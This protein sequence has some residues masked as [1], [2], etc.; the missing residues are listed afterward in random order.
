MIKNIPQ[1]MSGSVRTCTDD[2]AF[3]KMLAVVYVK[4]I[5]GK[6]CDN[7]KYR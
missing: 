6:K 5:M 4:S 1:G 2:T 7:K 3:E